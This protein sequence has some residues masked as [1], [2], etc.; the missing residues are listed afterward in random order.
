MKQDG[1]ETFEEMVGPAGSPLGRIR[2][3]ATNRANRTRTKIKAWTRIRL[4]F[5][6]PA[7][8]LLSGL[9]GGID[10]PLHIFSRDPLILYVPVGGRRPLYALAAFCRRLAPRRATFLLMPNWTLERPAVVEQIRKD[11]S[12]FAR[13]CPK[14][15]L[16]FLC[17]TEEERRLI[18]GVGGNAIFSNHN[19]MISEDVF[20]P[21][22][23]VPV[24]YDAV[25][26]GRISHT[27]RHYLA[28]EIERLVHVTSSIGEL[29]PAGDRAF[30]RRLQAQSPLHSIANPLLDGLPGRL[31]SAEVN[32]V[33]NQAAVG[34]CLSAVEGAMYSSMEYLLAGLPIV[35][36]PSIGGRDVYFDPD[37]CI[38]A[39]PEPTAIR[40][41]VER[42]RDRAIPREEI[43]GRT[44][45]RVRAERLD[46]MAYLSALKRRM[47]SDDPP[48]SEWPFAGTSGLTRWASVRD[49]LR[50]IVAISSGKI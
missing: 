27:K 4:P 11:L 13:V 38:V 23:D 5:I 19:L 6:L 12:W 40:R 7:R 46:L 21:L 3:L 10:M 17:N 2:L 45:E 28:F 39:E 31:T 47:G 50:E 14:H 9:D 32:R 16:I 20:R 35:S 37:Y 34:L 43:R 25:Y 15:Q 41:A 24:E 26:N 49:H 44:L 48:F 33:Y 8:G 1:H 42:L 30:I 18:G 22:Q 36:T 29:P